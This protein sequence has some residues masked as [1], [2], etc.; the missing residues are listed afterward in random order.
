M[1]DDLNFTFNIDDIPEYIFYMPSDEELARYIPIRGEDGAF[2]YEVADTLPETGEEGVLYFKPKPYTSQ[3]ATGNPIT[4]TITEGAGK[5]DSA[6]IDGDTYQQSY[7]GKNIYKVKTASFRGIDITMNADGS[8]DISGTVSGGGCYIIQYEPISLMENGATYSWWTNQESLPSGL[9]FR[10]ALA[11]GETWVRNCATEMTLSNT[12]RT[13]T[14]NTTGNVNQ[15]RSEIYLPNGTSVDLKGV[16]IQCEKSPTRTDFEPYVGG[17]PSPNPDYPQAIQTVTGLQTVSINGTDYTVDLGS[18]E[19]CKLGT[20]HDF[21]WKDGDDWKVHKANTKTSFNGTEAG[22]NATGAS[23]TTPYFIDL[24]ERAFGNYC[25]G[26]STHF[27]NRK[28]YP[29]DDGEFAIRTD[30]TSISF[31]KSGLASKD[32]WLSWLGSNS[33]TAYYPLA[34]GLVT[35]TTI[36]DATLIAQLEAVANARLASGSNTISNS[37]TSPNL[38]GDL[39]VSYHG[40]DPV[41]KY[42]KYVW[43]DLDNS[44]EQI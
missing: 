37:A 8:F 35:D 3:T 44:Y 30:G 13:F 39:E 17:A 1:S 15:I 36:T 22:W 20:Y 18:I 2:K 43:L 26:I 42:D 33:V 41:N 40:Y 5:L 16:Q 10:L 27:K 25:D 34:A 32:A 31:N 4:A 19:L 21:I 12:S 9:Y 38:A 29:S 24:P 6:Q 28:A 11:N 7:T 23:Q 14:A